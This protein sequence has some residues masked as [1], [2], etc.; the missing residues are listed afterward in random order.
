MENLTICKIANGAKAIYWSTKVNV[1]EGTKE[2]R[3]LATF[4]LLECF[5]GA[6][7]L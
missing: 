7:P 1:G 4:P 3:P 2:A 5:H 6:W